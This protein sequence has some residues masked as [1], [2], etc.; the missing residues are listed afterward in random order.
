M[1]FKGTIRHSVPFTIDLSPALANTAP[2]GATFISIIRRDR[3]HEVDTLTVPTGQPQ[4]SRT[5]TLPSN[6][7]RLEVSVYPP[8]SGIVQVRLTQG[9]NV[10]T[11]DCTGDATLAFDVTA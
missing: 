1:P 3:I 9:P 4:A 10:I 2:S 7:Q 5:D 6:V 11:H 8:D